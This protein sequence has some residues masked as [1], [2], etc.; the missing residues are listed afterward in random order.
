M[1]KDDDFSFI[2]VKYEG[3]HL[4]TSRGELEVWRS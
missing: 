3:L 4:E 2:H 1:R